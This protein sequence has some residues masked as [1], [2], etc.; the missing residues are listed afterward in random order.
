MKLKSEERVKTVSTTEINLLAF[1]I[2]LVW[3]IRFFLGSFGMLKIIKII[4][5]FSRYKLLLSFTNNFSLLFFF[6]F[7]SSTKK[8]VAPFVRH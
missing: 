8:R 6:A 2:V 1:D 3:Q 5:L 4:T 7:K